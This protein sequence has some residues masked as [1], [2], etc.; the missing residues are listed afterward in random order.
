M[1]VKRKHAYA[2]RNLLG[3]IEQSIPKEDKSPVATRER[4]LIATW[5][6]AMWELDWKRMV[7]CMQ[8][9]AQLDS[10]RA[11]KLRLAGEAFA[12]DFLHRA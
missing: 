9:L 2:L 10:P 4:D 7:S 1:Q 6:V 8:R 5:A 12:R 3:D 11:D